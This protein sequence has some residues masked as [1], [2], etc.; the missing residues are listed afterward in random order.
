MESEAK[1]SWSIFILIFI[2]LWVIFGVIGFFVWFNITDLDKL[3]ARLLYYGLYMI[4]ITYYS[5]KRY[6]Q[7]GSHRSY[8]FLD[9]LLIALAFIIWLGLQYYI[10][11]VGLY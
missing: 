7:T 2:A 11:I 9:L 1:K 4:L 8:L 6:Y 5:A 10:S 3:S